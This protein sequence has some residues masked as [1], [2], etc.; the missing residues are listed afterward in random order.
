MLNLSAILEESVRSWPE[1]TALTWRGHRLR[2]REVGSMADLV[3][4]R[5]H[6]LGIRPGDRVALSCPN[7]PAFVAG[8]HGILR[9]GAVVVP[10]DPLL[11]PTERAWHM[12][13]SGAAA[14]LRASPHEG[15]GPEAEPILSAGAGGAGASVPVLPLPA[16]PLPGVPASGGWPAS[17]PEGD[18]RVGRPGGTGGM[19]G[20]VYRAPD[21]V[22]ALLY[23]SGTTGRPRG[24]LLTHANLL[25]NALV[26]RGITGRVVDLRE[27]QVRLVALP[28]HHAYGQTTLLNAGFLNGDRLV[29]MERFLPREAL[30]TM[31]S[32]GVTQLS[33]VPAMY[34]RM[35][36]VLAED[37]GDRGPSSLRARATR[38]LALCNVGGAPLRPELLAAME[39][40]LGAVIL[41]GY[42][43]TETSPTAT[44]QPPD[45]PRKP[46]SVGRP[47]FGTEIRV[48]GPDG[49]TLPAGESG[50]ILIRGHGVMKGYHGLPEASARALR[51]GWLH[52]GDLGHLDA[53]GFLYLHGRLD[54]AILRG[55]RKVHPAEVEA[56]LEAHPGVDRA[57]VAGVPDVEL[58]EEVAAWV[59]VKGGVPP[60]R[61]ELESWC[62]ERLAPYR[63][64]RR[65]S[66]VEALPLTRTG[67]VRRALLRDG[68]A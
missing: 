60:S 67:K 31:A 13:D 66:F 54:D 8:Y 35:M 61:A 44:I 24:V 19:E 37:C 56:V 52:T 32:E 6:A 39:E 18:D 49:T 28:L 43:L 40:Q 17:A 14:L 47:V 1:R 20:A 4:V 29:L 41:E 45:G 62:R 63:V 64:P 51:D 26:S 11:T 59:V 46:G 42:G 33:G 27:P 5:L 3:S 48:V 15:E 38:R 36:S 57:G 7:T 12:E 50:E 30:E 65:W 10:L 25:V 58:G 2:Y 55:G 53:D 23:T 9:T 34:H 16:L 21:D 22:A 68:A